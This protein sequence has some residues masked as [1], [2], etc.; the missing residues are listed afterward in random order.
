M[1]LKGLKKQAS[2]KNQG[3][4]KVRESEGILVS[5]AYE[6]CNVQSHH[7]KQSSVFSSHCLLELKLYWI[8]DFVYLSIGLLFSLIFQLTVTAAV[9]QVVEGGQEVE[10]GEVEVA[11]MDTRQGVVAVDSLMYMDHIKRKYCF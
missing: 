3:E 2:S 4:A 5:N 9:A 1:A 8:F 10:R 7:K 11:I 6:P